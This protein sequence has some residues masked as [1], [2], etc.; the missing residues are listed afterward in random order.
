MS[1]MTK[2]AR[3]HAAH[4]RACGQFTTA[5]LLDDIATWSD[6]QDSTIIQQRK[7]IAELQEAVGTFKMKFKGGANQTSFKK[8]TAE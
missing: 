1:E 7:Q 8:E 4:C 3:T 5:K 2:D 6:I